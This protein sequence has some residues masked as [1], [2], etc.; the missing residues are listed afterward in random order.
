[1]LF[2]GQVSTLY[3]CFKS[4][5]WGAVAITVPVA[6]WIA[7]WTSNPQVLG[8]TPRWDDRFLHFVQFFYWGIKDQL[9]EVHGFHSVAVI[10][11]ASHAQGRRFEPGWKHQ[12]FASS[13]TLIYHIHRGQATRK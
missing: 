11:C 9:S 12:N 8:S 2:L 10:T 1:M 13:T 6:Q 7:R 3:V 5:D 4:Y